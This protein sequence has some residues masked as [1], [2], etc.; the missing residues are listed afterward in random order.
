MSNV[1]FF[2]FERTI[3]PF[4]HTIPAGHL[5]T[6]EVPLTAVIREVQEETGLTITN[7]VLKLQEN[8]IGDK[9][10]RGF[11]SVCRAMMLL[12]KSLSKICTSFLIRFP[13]INSC[14]AHKRFSMDM[15]SL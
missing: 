1:K 14:H 8:V 10:K 7:F 9:C 4:V 12:I 11:R 13:L 2:F 6:G 15:I 3:F 5:D